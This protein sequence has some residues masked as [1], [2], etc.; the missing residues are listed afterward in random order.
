[1]TSKDLSMTQ[2]KTIVDKY[3]IIHTAWH[4]LPTTE[5][6]LDY[7]EALAELEDN[8]CNRTTSFPK[9]RLHKVAG[10]R[11][12][13]YRADVSK[14]SDWRIHVQHID[15]K[16]Y[17]KD[18]NNLTSRYSNQGQHFLTIANAYAR[19]CSGA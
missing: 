15:G 3:G 19:F 10:L 5:L 18:H 14:I 13:I 4:K 7:L 8:E 6:K 12:A 1:M 16:L 17:L 11:Q 2:F 9:T